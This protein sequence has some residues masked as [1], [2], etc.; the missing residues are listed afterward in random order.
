LTRKSRKH[1][2]SIAIPIIQSGKAR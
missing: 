1:Q 2:I